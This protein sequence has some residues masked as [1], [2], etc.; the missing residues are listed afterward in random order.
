MRT[1]CFVFCAGRVRNLCSSI[2]KNHLAVNPIL[3]PFRQQISDRY[4]TPKCCSSASVNESL[5]A[6]EVQRNPI[7]RIDAQERGRVERDPFSQ[8]QKLEDRAQLGGAL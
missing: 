6:Q 4:P 8:A 2:M 7:G 5:N 3:I 1:G